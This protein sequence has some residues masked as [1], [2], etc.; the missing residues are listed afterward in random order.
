MIRHLHR[1]PAEPHI[2]RQ[3]PAGKRLDL[4]RHIYFQSRHLIRQV[5][6]HRPLLRC[7]LRLQHPA[8]QLHPAIRLRP[9]RERLHIAHPRKLIQI[10]IVHTIHRH[11][12]RR[13]IRRRNQRLPQQGKQCYDYEFFR[14]GHK[15]PL[16]CANTT[17]TYYSTGEGKF[18]LFI[19]VCLSF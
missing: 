12:R 3:L 4:R 16:T 13:L 10:L 2:I 7:L 14:N 1:H 15:N 8:R 9:I 19:A 18:S 17:F 11:I 6:R 5:R